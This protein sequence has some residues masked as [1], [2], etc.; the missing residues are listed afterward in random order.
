MQAANSWRRRLARH[1]ASKQAAAFGN[2]LFVLHVYIATVFV[3]FSEHAHRFGV[4]P[5][6]KKK[7]KKIHTHRNTRTDATHTRVLGSPVFIRVRIAEREPMQ[8]GGDSSGGG[9]GGRDGGLDKAL[10][11]VA[12]CIHSQSTAHP[13]C[14]TESGVLGFVT[15]SND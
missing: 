6:K 14:S 12:E 2:R 7:K 15:K 11:F 10:S 1:A 5:R 8:R 3:F 13:V 4:A 9:G